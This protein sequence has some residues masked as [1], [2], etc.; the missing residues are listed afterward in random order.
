MQQEAASQGGRRNLTIFV[1][2]TDLTL[3]EGVAGGLFKISGTAIHP[4]KTHH[5]REWVKLRE[6][7]EPYLIQAAPSLT[8]APVTIDHNVAIPLTDCRITIST[9]N[10]KDGAVYY[11]GLVN[12]YV[13]DLIRTGK[14]KGVSLG[15]D[16]F[17]PGGGIIVGEA[18]QVIPYAFSFNEFSLI[19]NMTPGDPETTIRLWEALREGIETGSFELFE[20]Q[21]QLVEAK[22]RLAQLKHEREAAKI[23]AEAR[24]VG[25]RE[26][27]KACI[28]NEMSLTFWRPGARMFARQLKETIEKYGGE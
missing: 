13:A 18:G 16:W 7:V 27:V 14:I 15:I 8:K 6:Y 22:E 26:A 4:V 21:Q 19:Q 28:P 25:L 20:I 24:F 2:A 12:A 3:R 5:P 9:W 23:A 1:F 10:E 11:E 17:K